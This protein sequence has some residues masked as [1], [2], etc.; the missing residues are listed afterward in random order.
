MD[1]V[2]LHT[3]HILYLDYVFLNNIVL[4]EMAKPSKLLETVAKPS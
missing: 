4:E 3:N 2:N 1:L